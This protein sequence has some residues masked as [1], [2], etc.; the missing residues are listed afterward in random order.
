VLAAYVYLYAIFD[1]YERASRP[2][3]PPTASAQELVA[4]AG[5]PERKAPAAPAR[6]DEADRLYRRAMVNLMMGLRP[7]ARDQFEAVLRR[8]PQDWDAHYQLGK[9]YLELGDRDKAREHLAKYLGARHDG[10]WRAEAEAALSS[11]S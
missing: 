6:D 2:A 11:L 10:K 4:D 3:T 9:V 1:A 5:A 7:A 8:N